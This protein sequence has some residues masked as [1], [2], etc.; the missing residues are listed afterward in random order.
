MPLQIYLAE[1]PCPLPQ[2]ADQ[3]NDQL[4]RDGR[5]IVVISEGFDVGNL[6]EV[7][8]AFGHT[9]FSASQMTVAQA[10]VNYLNKVG[11]AAKGAARGNVPGTDQRSSM[12]YASTVDL[13]EAY[14]AGQMAAELAARGESGYMATILRN[15]GSVYSVRYDKAPF[16]RAGQ[17]R[18]EVSR[19]MGH[20]GQN[21]RDGRL[22]PVRQATGRRRH[23]QSTHDRR[24]AAAHAVPAGLCRSEA[25]RLRARSGPPGKQNGLSGV[26]V[27]SSPSGPLYL[28]LI[29]A[30]RPRATLIPKR[31]NHV[32]PE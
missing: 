13:D 27:F 20:L 7:K 1:F 15:P 5:C 17:Q 19:L 21:R 16:V 6:G 12:A 18:T 25:G 22:C 10:L 28:P 14:R 4:K 23:G 11:L 32:D 9:S 3:V 29:P 24:P 31:T 26:S 8:D 2:L 30:L